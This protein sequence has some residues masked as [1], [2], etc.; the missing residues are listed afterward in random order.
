M[1]IA[2]SGR[3]FD[4]TERGSEERSVLAHVPEHGRTPIDHLGFGID[5]IVGEDGIG[6]CATCDSM[7]ASKRAAWSRRAGRG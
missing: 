3:S 2:A 4:L 6:D 1:E 5:R 7:R